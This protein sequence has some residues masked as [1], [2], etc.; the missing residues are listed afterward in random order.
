[1]PEVSI[2]TPVYANTPQKVAW[3]REAV[4]SVRSQTFADWEM[5]VVDDLS[6][7]ALDLPDDERVR[8]V[9]TTR[10]Y[11]P[12]AARNTAAARADGGALLPLDAD[13]MLVE[14]ALGKM[15]D[16]WRAD[17]TRV[18]YGDLRRLD[19]SPDG[20]RVKDLHLPDY[21]FELSLKLTGII[22]VTAMHSVECHE[23]AG[24]WKLD[25]EHGL[26]DVEYWISAGK[27]GFCGYHLPELTLYYRRH[28][29]SRFY[30]LRHV[31]RLESDMRKAIR[32]R[33][34]DVYD[35]RYPMG[36]CG[37]SSSSSSSPKPAAKAGPAVT[38]LDQYPAS[39][40][41]WVQYNGK[42][43]ASFGM[44]GASTGISYQVLGPGHKFEVHTSDVHR[45]A[46][47][48]R[49]KDFR[50]GVPPPESRQATPEPEPKATEPAYQPPA[51]E[52][53]QIERLD[54][55][56]AR[57]RTHMPQPVTEPPKT[58]ENGPRPLDALNLGALQDVLE[59]ESWTVEGLA[60]ADPDELTGYK[61]IGPVRAGQIIKRAQ[62]L[63]RG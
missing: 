57:A 22:P 53:A 32:E 11:G 42:R 14:D 4:E 40:K 19:W 61:G 34:K 50:V 23:R 59:M 13:D 30:S 47:S 24:G 31:R 20:W 3:L 9:R 6:D 39:E 28:E 27:A 36:C 29:T 5:I 62:E 44:V 52:L 33:H 7:L 18:V 58:Q 15:Y 55:V 8:R 16:A 12:A 35:G 43:Q 54:P 60:V 49:G 45:F 10:R 63:S 41:I 26:E 25:L 56:G 48:G 37:G 17:P 38:T 2:I 1:L 46:R 51:P 21:T